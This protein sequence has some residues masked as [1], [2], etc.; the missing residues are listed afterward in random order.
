MKVGAVMFCFVSFSFTVIIPGSHK[1]S[2]TENLLCCQIA[3]ILQVYLKLCDVFN[4][5]NLRLLKSVLPLEW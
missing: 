3:W 2:S 4:P 1:V 5:S